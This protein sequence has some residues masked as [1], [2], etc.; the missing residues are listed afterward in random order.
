M[1]RPSLPPSLTRR[2]VIKASGAVIAAGLVGG[3][4]LLAP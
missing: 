3:A 2:D 1:D 4:N